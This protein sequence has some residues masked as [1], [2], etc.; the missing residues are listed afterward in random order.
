MTLKTYRIFAK[1][2]EYYCTEGEARNE[3]EA[4]EQYNECDSIDWEPLLEGGN[5]ESYDIEEAE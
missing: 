2:E 4:W 5:F 1:R 3:E